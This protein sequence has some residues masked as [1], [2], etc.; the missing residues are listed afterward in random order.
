MKVGCTNCWFG[1]IMLVRFQNRLL[2]KSLSRFSHWLCVSTTLDHTYCLCFHSYSVIHIS[3]FIAHCSSLLVRMFYRPWCWF[4]RVLHSRVDLFYTLV[5]NF[6]FKKTNVLNSWSRFSDLNF[7]LKMVLGAWTGL[8]WSLM[9]L[10]YL[11][12]P[13]SRLVGHTFVGAVIT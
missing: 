8:M 1:I 3:P 9:I 6:H 2:W 12:A 13:L 11:L 7:M 4:P 10:C 5:S